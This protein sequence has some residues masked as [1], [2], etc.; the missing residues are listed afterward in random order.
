MATQ[1]EILRIEVDNK[2]AQQNIT[3]QTKKIEAL[4]EE[5]KQ[6]LAINKKLA[7]EEGD[8]SKERARN[9]QTIA[10][11]AAVISKN[12]QQRK[13]N[14]SVL[15]NE[16]NT[17]NNLRSQLAL[18]TAERNKN[19]V[20]GTKA[21]NNANKQ[22]ASYNKQIRSAEE[23]GGDFRRSVGNYSRAFE[24]ATA[25]ILPFNAALLASPIGAIVAALGALVALG[26]QVFSFFKEFDTVMS[27]VKATTSATNEEFQKLK[28]STIEFGESSKFTATEVAKLQ[29][30]LAKLGFTTGEIIDATGAILDLA[31]ATDSELAESAKVLAQ[32]LNQFQLEA[33]ESQRVADVMAKSF[34]SSAL[35]IEKFSTA[36]SVAAPA[37]D[38]VGATLE[39]TTAILAKLSDAGVDASTSGTALRNIF[40]DLSDQGLS[41]EDA[42]N[43][44]NQSQNKLLRANELFGKRGAVVAQIISN[45]SDE[46]NT[47]TKSFQDAEGSAAAMAEI[48]GNNLQGDLDRLSSSW[49]GLIAR[50][51]GLNKIFRAVVTTITFLVDGIK[52]LGSDFFLI[53]SPQG[54]VYVVVKRFAN[55]IKILFGEVIADSLR[56][57]QKGAAFFGVQIDALDKA[58]SEQIEKNRKNRQKEEKKDQEQ[59][60]TAWEKYRKNLSKIFSEE[61]DA[62]TAEKIKGANE[63]VKIS[64]LETQTEIDNTKK[65][66]EEKKKAAQKQKDATFDLELFRK[67]RDA[68]DIID[69]DEKAKALIAIEE[70][71]L[72]KKLDNEG[73]IETEREILIEQSEQRILN[74]KANAKSELLKQEEEAAEKKEKLE[75]EATKKQDKEEK[76]RQKLKA[77]T[78]QNGLDLTQAAVGLAS[79]ILGRETKAGKALAITAAGINTAQAITKTFAQLGGT[80]LGFVSAAAVGAAGVKQISAIQSA[81]ASGTSGGSSN[82]SVPSPN[83]G[84]ST[85]QAD[86][87]NVDNQIN[88]QELLIEITKVQRFCN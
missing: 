64:N 86:T 11:N 82:I 20:V 43:S 40:I 62:Q 74:I 52:Q 71:E 87:S 5:N 88:E 38:A 15:Q 70:F 12:T 34:V 59:G 31:T 35:D 79:E 6:L 25:S 67:K 42:M 18:L 85:A 73:L 84:A 23:G 78:I 57:L 24:G 8:T 77:K 65:I 26:G 50:G 3:D 53:F 54:L 45:Q 80:P 39:Q 9:S 29:L 72:R 47:L 33:N 17:L 1:T 37:A 75:D 51:G 63:R 58:L 36:M 66:L 21:F 68:D 83:V 7:K 76:K 48:V 22:I 4:K 10:K 49:E 60:E 14:I 13:Q 27:K 44:I 56:I 81:G 69:A 30:E 55:D 16:K 61:E 2:Q 28:E 46:I 41:W 19:L 32:T